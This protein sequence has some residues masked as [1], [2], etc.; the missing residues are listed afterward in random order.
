MINKVEICGVNTSKL[1]VLKND[2]M[3]ILF[4][5]MQA[6]D[7]SARESLIQGNLRLVLS[8]IQRFSNR[9]EYVDDLFQV[10]CI[11]LIKAIDNFDLGQ[12]VRF[13]T[14]AV[15]MIIG[16]IRR[17]LRDNNS[18]RVSRSLRDIAYKALQ[19]RERLVAEQ[20]N[21]P[22]ISQIAQELQVPREEVVFA[23]D[24]IQDPVSLFEPIYND[25]GDP[26]LVMDQISDEHNSDDLW[27]EEITINEAMKKL[28][29][30][31]K[32]IVS[33]RF[34][35]GK[36]QMEVADEI[37]ISQAQVSRL[38]KAALKQLRKHV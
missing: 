13:S 14:Y 8:V 26:I 16:E 27:L 23:L 25:G 20:A 12:N 28:N 3:R 2:E 17:Y 29:E 33:L 18:V 15:P 7:I 30:R 38:E 11:G 4:G 37:G 21:E 1:P 34:F 31:E 9:G 24:A 22:T 32:H 36:T 5:K 19:I 35:H 6:G 10:G